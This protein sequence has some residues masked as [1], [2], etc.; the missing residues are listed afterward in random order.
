M[1]P[2]APTRMLDVAAAT[3][4]MAIDVAALAMPGMLWCSASQKRRYPQRSACRARSTELRS[5]WAASLPSTIGA[6][7]RTDSDVMRATIADDL[8]G[9]PGRVPS[10]SRDELR[11]AKLA[12]AHAIDVGQSLRARWPR[13]ARDGQRLGDLGRERRWQVDAVGVQ[14]E[15]QDRPVLVVGQAARLAGRHVGHRELGDVRHGDELALAVLAVCRWVHRE[16]AVLEAHHLRGLGGSLGGVA[17]AVGAVVGV[18]LL[19]LRDLVGKR[20]RRRHARARRRRWRWI[21]GAP[22]QN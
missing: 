7:S 10:P 5:A 15:G 1:I 22:P 2:P 18:E 6:R 11:R 3:W 12:S 19:A 16:R 14:V 4:A 8:G 17:V 9:N 20:G 21:G 13:L